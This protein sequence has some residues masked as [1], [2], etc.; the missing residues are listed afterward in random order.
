MRS[1]KAA[2]KPQTPQVLVPP[3]VCPEPVHYTL[4]RG[5]ANGGVFLSVLLSFFNEVLL[6][7][8][9]YYDCDV[10][11]KWQIIMQKSLAEV[12]F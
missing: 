4:M 10:G 8:D 1:T 6:C 7:I 12:R 3:W 2:W 11:T 9:K 5:W